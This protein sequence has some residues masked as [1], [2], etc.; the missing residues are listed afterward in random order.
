MKGKRQIFLNVTQEQM[1][2]LLTF[3][4]YIHRDVKRSQELYPTAIRLYL[5]FSISILN[6][7]KGISEHKT[8]TFLHSIRLMGTIFVF[9]FAFKLDSFF[10]IVFKHW[11]VL[12]SRP[13]LL[14]LQQPPILTPIQ[15]LFSNTDTKQNFFL[16]T[17]STTYQKSQAAS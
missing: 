17:I 4:I 12:K 3:C 1:L 16:Q 14:D 11:S 9:C 8:G 10:L 2:A 6:L 5:H 15:T 7:K 13:S